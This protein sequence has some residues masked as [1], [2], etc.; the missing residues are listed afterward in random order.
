MSRL[1][2]EDTKGKKQGESIDGVAPGQEQAFAMTDSGRRKDRTASAKASSTC[3]YCGE[4][5][6]WIAKC[7]ARIRENTER[8]RS[9]RANVAQ[10]EDYSADYLFS[11]G[12][13]KCVTKSSCVWPVDSSKS[14]MESI[15]AVEWRET[16]N[17][18]IESLRRNK[19]W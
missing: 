17:S 9:Q 8:Q 13:T 15:E 7:P 16:C 10:S 19:T 5:G 1:L 18:E 3:H 4:L 14:A 2:H 11:V 6:H 12:G